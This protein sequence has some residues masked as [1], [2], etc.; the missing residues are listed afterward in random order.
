MRPCTSNAWVFAVSGLEG[1]RFRGLMPEYI[2]ISQYQTNHGES[3][4]NKQHMAHEMDVRLMWG[5]H[6]AG[7]KGLNNYQFLSSL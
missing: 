6:E 5:L 1:L 3:G 4:G 7:I 2:P